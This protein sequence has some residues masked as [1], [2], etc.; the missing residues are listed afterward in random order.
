MSDSKPRERRSP[1]SWSTCPP[2]ASRLARDGMTWSIRLTVTWTALRRLLPAGQRGEGGVGGDDGDLP[3]QAG[4][5]ESEAHVD[6]QP[7]PTGG[8]ARVG[9][10]ELG[11]LVLPGEDGRLGGAA[12]AH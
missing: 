9:D 1:R 2:M 4:G 8:P 10:L 7:H 6:R 11:H 12:H 5:P 3:G